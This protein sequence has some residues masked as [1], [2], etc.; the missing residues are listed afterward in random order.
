MSFSG[1]DHADLIQDPLDRG[2]VVPG[3]RLGANC[4]KTGA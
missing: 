4:I 2:V 1:V 3:G